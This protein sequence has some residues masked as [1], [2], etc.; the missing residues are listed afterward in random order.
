M[1]PIWSTLLL[2][3]TGGMP[4]FANNI[5]ISALKIEKTDQG[6]FIQFTLAWENAWHNAKNHDA[7]WLVVKFKPQD[8]Y[9]GARHCLL[10]AENHQVLAKIPSNIPDPGFK[11][12]ADNVGLFVYPGEVYR[13]NVQWNLRLSLNTRGSGIGEFMAGEWQVYALE[14]VYVPAGAYYLGDP[15]T[16]SRT[17]AAF[18]GNDPNSLFKVEQEDQPIAIGSQPGQLNYRP[19]EPIYQGDRQGPIPAAFPKGAQAFYIQKYEITQGSYASFLNNLGAQASYF[20]SNF[21]GKDYSKSRGSLQFENDRYAAKSPNRPLNFVSWDDGCA[22]ADWAGLRPMTE[23]EF[24]K[25]CRG[26]EAP[27]AHQFP[28][29]SDNK[30]DLARF[31][32]LDD[33]L[34]LKA[35]NSEAQLSDQTRAVFGASYWWVMDL[36]GSLWERVV[37]IGHPSGRAYRG[38]HGDGRLSGYGY[39]TN[40]DWPFG[41]DERT[42]GYGYRGGG[43]YEHG[44]PETSFNP[45][46]PISWRNY[47]AWAGGPRSIA[48]G[49]RCVRTAP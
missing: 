15:D 1:K 47:A 41:D 37:S 2:I 10:N 24:E 21:G 28:W 26:P 25:A 42:G 33:E 22:F 36:A 4:L 12:S 3:L 17:A 48:Y 19:N 38:T 49:F 34:K 46:S 18:F 9:S 8:P 13:G 45:H 11:V 29:G 20:R 39:A 27:I 44:K 23:L 5:S 43:Y 14:M 32:D 6:T 40:A 7:A 31:V 16:L 30:K 35:G